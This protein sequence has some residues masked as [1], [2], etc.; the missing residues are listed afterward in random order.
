[1]KNVLIFV[2]SVFIIGCSGSTKSDQKIEKKI[3][4]TVV[5]IYSNTMDIVMPDTLKAGL[6]H[7]IYEN[8]SSMTHFLLFN[9][10]PE[11]V[12][13]NNYH[14][15]LTL[16]FQELMDAITQNREPNA[17][18]PEWLGEM[19]NMGG[20]GLLS[21]GQTAESYVN[22]TTGN[23]IVECYIKSNGIFHSTSGMLKQITVISNNQKQINPAASVTIHVDSLGLSVDGNIPEHGGNVTFKITYGNTK[24]Y[25][26]FT[27]PDVHLVKITESAS[28]DKLEDYMDWTNPLGM[29]V[30]APVVFLGGAQEMPKGNTAYFRQ[31]LSTG[32]Y[33]LIGEVPNPKTNGF[34]IEFEITD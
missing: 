3:E 6:N 5:K 10:V 33:I 14:E 8:N 25:S 18:F 16:P 20:V 21:P 24:L 12:N 29:D 9:K 13:L 19:I 22:L 28:V 7:L 34:Y 11:I 17:T 15:E 4:P 30:L 32:K 27:R 23:Y 31:N 26:N 2:I 1:M